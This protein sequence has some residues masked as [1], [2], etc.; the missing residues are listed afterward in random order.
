MKIDAS[1][2]FPSLAFPLVVGFSSSFVVMDSTVHFFDLLNK[3][4]LTPPAWVFGPVWTLLYIMIG[5]ALY[6]FWTS[7]APSKIKRPGYLFF[8]L[9]IITNFIWTLL[10]FGA[11]SPW[12]GMIDIVILLAMIITNLILFW[13]IDKN[14]G[15]LLLPYLVWVAFA[16][17]L[18]I[19]IWLLN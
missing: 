4:P 15:L 16:A 11:R 2:L 9:Q 6:F 10:F 18:N 5:L 12:M 1:K 3:P 14:S 17:Y 19:G 7:K 8:L 13:R